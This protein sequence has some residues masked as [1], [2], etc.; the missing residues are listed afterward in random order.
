MTD[1]HARVKVTQNGPYTVQDAVPLAVQVIEVDAEGES[2]EWREGRTFDSG[3]PYSLCR[4]GGSAHKPFCDDT[5]VK[6]RFDG[7]ET[8]SRAPSA[9]QA[10]TFDGPTMELTD[11]ESLSA[12]APSC[13]HDGPP[14]PLLVQSDQ[15][16]PRQ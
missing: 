11:A 15:D 10:E 6:I 3:A 13:A 16:G 4:C 9:D 8:A 12:F 14:C 5:H 7:T 1:R 2:R